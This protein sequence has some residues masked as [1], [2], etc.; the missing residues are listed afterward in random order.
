[1]IVL[2]EDGED[3]HEHNFDVAEEAEA[4]DCFQVVIHLR[5]EDVLHVDT[6][7]VLGGIKEVCL[8]FVVDAG[9][10]CHAC[11]QQECC[12]HL[13]GVLIGVF[14]HLGARA[15]KG[16]GATEDVD[17]LAYL[18]E[19]AFSDKFPYAS[20]PSVAADGD[21]RAFI[22][23]LHHRA[24]F[25]YAEVLA[26]LRDALLPIENRSLRIKLDRDRKD[27]EKGR[28]AYKHQKRYHDVE[29]SLKKEGSS[30]LF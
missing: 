18:V 6:V 13:G 15:D 2:A 24:E 7:G 27:Q 9:E 8:V 12:H 30:L 22:G 17:K 11:G 16:H 1:M 20:Y 4:L 29:G 28:E 25:E 5:G 23:V 21:E 14:R 19:T 10:A 3:G 26:V